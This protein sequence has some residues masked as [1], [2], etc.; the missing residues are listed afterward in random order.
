MQELIVKKSMVIG[1]E[2]AQVWEALTN[3]KI[4]KKYFFNCEVIS[5]WEVDSS[6]IY[7]DSTGKDPIDHVTGTLKYFEEG[8]MFEY[9]FKS[10]AAADGNRSQ[11]MRVTFELEP[12]NGRTKLTVTQDCGDNEKVY[13]DSDMGWDY[14][15]HGLKKLLESQD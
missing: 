13:K 14:V 11:M 7:R 12:E 9:T 8:K 1:A 5:D 3:P 4:T 2:P 10:T 6:I 15:L